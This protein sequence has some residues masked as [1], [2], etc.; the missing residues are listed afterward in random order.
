MTIIRWQDHP[1]KPWK[2]GFGTTHEIAVHPQHA[3]SDTFIW[4]V[5]VAEVD[6]AAPFSTFPDIDRHIALLDGA[7]FTMTIDGK[8]AHA[9]RIPFESF[10]FR[11]ESSVDVTLTNGPTRDFNL[12]TRRTHAR[13]E[14]ECWHGPADRIV[15]ADIVLLYVARG[16]F[17]TAAGELGIGDA[18]LRTSKAMHTVA[19]HDEAVVMV[20]RI[21]LLPHASD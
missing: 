13:G 14:V 19:L 18:W 16:S 15:D 1:P 12:M 20:V 10:L 6:S 5:S 9:L 3:D 4:R 7:G 11:G 8:R 21:H 2:N 17:T